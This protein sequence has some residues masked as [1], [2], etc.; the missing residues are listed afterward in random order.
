M[1]SAT[2]C[3]RWLFG[4]GL[5]LLLAQAASA[6]LDS[7]MAAIATDAPR[8]ELGS[9]IQVYADRA[10]RFAA[11]DILAGRHEEDRVE[12]TRAPPNL[13]YPRHPYW[14]VLALRNDGERPLDRLLTLWR[15]NTHRQLAHILVEPDGVPPL[16]LT[17][18]IGFDVR[19]RHSVVRLSLP[20]HS[21]TRVAI[22]LQTATALSLDYRLLDA[23]ELAAIDRVDY[24]FFG[25]L[26]GIVGAIGIYVLAL[27]FALRE[28]L[29][30]LFAGFAFGNVLYQLHTEGY[31]YLLW[32][33]AQR[34]W[35]NALGTFGGTLFALMII[36]FIRDYMNLPTLVP[37]LDRWLLGPVMLL[38]C[39]VF[40]SYPFAPW[41]GNTLAA[42]GVILGTVVST[43][44]ALRGAT[45]SPPVW[46]FMIA[47][48]AF[49][50]LGVV[51]LLK[52]IGV[53]PDLQSLALVLQLGSAATT[54]AFAIAVM[55]RIRRVVEEKRLAQL[56]YADRLE[57]KVAA[58]T[59]EL[60]EAKEGAERALA[61]LQSTRKQLLEADKMASLGQLV[62]G[63][64]HEVNT[65][66]GIA[67]T[68]SSHLTE[69]SATLE[70]R[71][72]RGELS[73]SELASYLS[74]T[75]EAGAMIERN[76]ER[77]AHLIRSFKQVS[78]DRTS[79]G[80]RRFDLAT[81]IAELIESLRLSWKRRPVRLTIDCPTGILLDSFPGALGQVITNLIQNAL[82]HGFAADQP[83]HIHIQAREV[84][85]ASVELVFED[86]GAGLD[87]ATLARIFDPFFTTKRNQGGTG[88]G[89]NIVYNL[90]A[91]K[92]G[93][94]ID[95]WSEPGRGLR[96][97]LR[98]PRKAPQSAEA[99]VPA[100]GE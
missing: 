64:S 100:S 77:A 13:G 23:E 49:F 7:R 11:A 22:R 14:A 69:R 71:L 52:R 75:R 91:Q 94:E 96:L 51:H 42:L 46:S 88:L 17:T 50:A 44:V 72:A 61:Q 21:T 74:E 2:A 78:V 12:I 33:E 9:A 63:V 95:A 47:T 24:W 59:A 89:L 97:T 54:I 34:G 86:D 38:L 60:R 35:G 98:L 65:P 10:G 76:L 5:S 79:D 30:L 92:L 80:R 87:A 28:R 85:T 99:A 40:V 36:Q 8:I 67:V 37:R 55:E 31:A 4:C 6:A 45:V 62:A 39:L 16:P 19:S 57:H 66:L 15:G 53:L 58:R 73:Q 27:F 93:G 84:D 32:P 3:L 41:L 82:L 18:S 26:A 48:L 29:Y 56:E 43:F 90:V 68:A 83:G 1:G 20:P 25:L 81:Q 70:K